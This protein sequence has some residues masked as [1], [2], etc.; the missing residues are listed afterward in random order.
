VDSARDDWLSLG[1]LTAPWGV[2]GEIKVQLDADPEFVG[3]VQRIYLG[4]QR[5]VRDVS[6]F[7]RRGRAYTFKLQGVESANE[8]ELLRGQEVYIPR[9]EAPPLPAGEYFFRDIVGLRVLT[10]D[11]RDLGRVAQVIATGANDVYVVRGDQGEI[12][13]PAIASV[14][15]EIDIAGGVMR[16][17]PIPGLLPDSA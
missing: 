8:A 2:R 5:Q 10:A 12:L 14:V 17:T 4:Q 16:I 13:V 6:S 3:Q 1:T 7:H 11:G 9:A 15:A